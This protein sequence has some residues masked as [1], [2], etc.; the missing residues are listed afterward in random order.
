MSNLS[1]CDMN[2]HI[3]MV[4]DWL[5]DRAD[6]ME[7]LELDGTEYNADSNRWVTVAH[8]DK[9]TYALIADGG[10]IRIEYIGSR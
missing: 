8:D 1:K 3:E 5:A 9:A 2:T 10:N 7:N 6:E 4:N